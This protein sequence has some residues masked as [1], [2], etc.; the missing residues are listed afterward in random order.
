VTI[1]LD[2]TD[3][4]NWSDWCVWESQIIKNKPAPVM[5]EVS[6]CAELLTEQICSSIKS[7]NSTFFG[8]GI[9]PAIMDFANTIEARIMRKIKTNNQQEEIK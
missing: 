3:E 1:V 9:Q 2:K 6:K 4:K 7:V 8:V 5:D